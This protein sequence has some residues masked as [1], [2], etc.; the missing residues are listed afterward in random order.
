MQNSFTDLGRKSSV[1][2]VSGPPMVNFHAKRNDSLR[3]NTSVP[4][5]NPIIFRE[6]IFPDKFKKNR[7]SIEF[8]GE[9]G[10]FIICRVEL[11]PEFDFVTL[12]QFF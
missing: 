10:R 3:S 8:N 6:F 11:T 7:K 1:L 12:Y 9:V 2:S 5:F 4:G